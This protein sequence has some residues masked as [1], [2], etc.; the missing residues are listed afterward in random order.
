MT[1]LQPA[2]PGPAIE[3]VV[4]DLDDTLYA[5]RD[6]V[7][8]GYRAVGRF[9]QDQCD[10]PAGIDEWM[11]QRFCAGRADR[12]FNAAAEQ[13]GLAL[14]DEQ[15]GRL[16]TVYREHRPSL[17]PHEDAVAVLDAL[18]GRVKMGLV[19][20][21]FLPAQQYKLEAIGLADRFDAVVFTESLGR[22]SWKPSTDGF[23]TLT[24]Q[25]N[26]AHEHCCYVGDN[27]AKDFVGPNRLGWRSILWRRDGQV[28]AHKPAPPGG[29]P[30]ARVDSAEA[31][32]ATLG[33]RT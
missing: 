6:Y 8:S 26:V 30:H 14:N 18:A 28:H 19:S 29:E 22:A 1:P 33:V 32:L 7:R 23:V 11:W 4:F 17:Q 31:L 27:L 12:M 13:F 15:I 25:L 20:D 21:G 24:R 10:A 2:H 3:A 5:E 9:L 16:V